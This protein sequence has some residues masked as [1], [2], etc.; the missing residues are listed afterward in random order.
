MIQEE[1]LYE[2]EINVPVFFS[3]LIRK[4]IRQKGRTIGRIHDL[5][6]TETAGCP[7]V[8]HL[9]VS[10]SF[11]KSPLIVPFE[12]VISIHH[13]TIEIGGESVSPFEREPQEDEFM[14]VPYILNQKIIDLQDHEIKIV[15][16][17]NLIVNMFNK[18]LVFEVDC[19]RI[20]LLRRAGFIWLARVL[21]GSI[22]ADLRGSVPWMY[23]QR[24]PPP[25]GDESGGFNFSLLK[26]KLSR[27]HPVDLAEIIEDMDNDQRAAI[28][29]ELDTS[30]ASDALEEI[31]PPIQREIVSGLPREKA[32]AVIDEMTPGQAADILSGLPVD[33]S[34]EILSVLSDDKAKKVKSILEQAEESILNYTTTK[35]IMLPPDAVV[36]DVQ[37]EYPCLAKDKDVIMYLYIVDESDILRGIIDIKELLKADHNA[38]LLDIMVYDLIT[39][40]PLS[41]L[42]EAAEEFS[43]YDFRSLPVTDEDNKI[44]GVVPYRDIMKHRKHLID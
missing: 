42:Q 34:R 23:I 17:L 11:L 8:T 20:A 2:R 24:L 37:E 27:M 4:K 18:L 7:E 30:M 32:I 12:A 22:D 35:F 40:S 26:E 39:L 21:Q 41:T 36:G 25:S 28:F 29:S 33:E 38:T 1:E 19:S 31:A 44:I 14:L 5:I 16:D 3:E 9:Y 10:G 13:R 6:I 15:R 43:R